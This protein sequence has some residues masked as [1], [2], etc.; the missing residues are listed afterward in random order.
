MT[1]AESGSADPG[2]SAA[3]TARARQR[4]AT[5]AAILAAARAQFARVGFERSTI[6]RIAE[7]AHVD[8]GLVMH[9]FGSKQQLFDQAARLP[10]E[11]VTGETAQDVAASL[12]AM[13]ADRITTQPDA[14]LA[15]LRSM[16]THDPAADTYRQVAAERLDQIAAAIPADHPELRACLLTAIVQGVIVQ[17]WLLGPNPLS[18]ACP[19]TVIALLRP[20]FAALVAPPDVNLG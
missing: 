17:R 1:P 16:L 14:S 15:V 18:E 5:E 4:R 19:E 12:L 20:C 3:D 6:R 10:D 13:L 11:P 9:Y 2:R 7:A 8:P